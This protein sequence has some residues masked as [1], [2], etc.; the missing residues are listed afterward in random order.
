MSKKRRIFDIDLPDDDPPEPEA[1]AIGGLRRGPM[2][3]AIGENADALR[4]RTEQESAIREENDT[5]AHEFVRLKKLGLVTDLIPLD[6]V[7]S[8]KLIRDRSARLDPEL[9]ELKA[10]ILALGL[11]NPIRVE[12]IAEGRYELVQGWRRLAAYRALYEETGDGRFAQIPAGLMAKGETL[13][14]LYRR[15]VDENM[16]RKDISWAEMA[17]LAQ[18]YADDPGVGC[19]DL[20]TAVNLLFATAAPQ[21]RSYIRRF[22]LLMRALDPIL[23]HPEAIPRALG[24]ELAHVIEADPSR[25]EQIAAALQAEQNRTAEAELAV[26]RQ[27]AQQRPEVISPPGS[28]NRGRPAKRG[29][30]T[31]RLPISGGEVRCTAAAGKVEL[32]STR[33]FSTVER[34]R[35][36]AA[37]EAFFAALE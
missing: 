6:Q 16:V 5:L 30:T 29:K 19:P 23:A 24:L 9:D 3:T 20:D 31:L 8:G 26:L 34:A 11:S 35:L 2:A 37:V 10:S 27:F 21:K 7:E 36:E 25:V 13:E 1:R 28:P 17:R 22:A 18:S 4:R 32:Y 15:M 12:Q 14:G 33:D